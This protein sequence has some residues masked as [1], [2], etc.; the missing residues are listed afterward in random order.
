MVPFRGAVLA[1]LLLLA[2]C[3]TPEPTATPTPTPGAHSDADAHCGR[4]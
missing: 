2:A 3:G 4:L 1:G